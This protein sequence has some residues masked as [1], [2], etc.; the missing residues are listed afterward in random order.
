MVILWPEA[1]ELYIIASVDWAFG[2]HVF[3]SESPGR[4]SEDYK[5]QEL[6]DWAHLQRST[7][8]PPADWGPE[9]CWNLDHQAPARA[10]PHWP[11][12]RAEGEWSAPG[13]G[14]EAP[15]GRLHS[16]PVCWAALSLSGTPHSQMNLK[17]R[18]F[19]KKSLISNTNLE[20]FHYDLK[21]GWQQP[22]VQYLNLLVPNLQ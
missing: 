20:H 8:I 1:Q 9:L 21:N 19:R 2:A 18:I 10:D 22:H 11:R 13:P 15:P 16:L 17:M 12:P 5:S 7:E 14:S 3:S 6:A 4:S